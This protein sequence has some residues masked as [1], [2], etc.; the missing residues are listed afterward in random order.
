MQS[1]D[2]LCLS[3]RPPNTFRPKTAYSKSDL[4]DH[5]SLTA[6]NPCCAASPQRIACSLIRPLF[7]SQ[8]YSTPKY[9]AS[10]IAAA[11]TPQMC[12][13]SLS[14]VNTC[15]LSHLRFPRPRN[16]GHAEREVD[17]VRLLFGRQTA[18]GHQHAHDAG[19][20][21]V[22]ISLMN[23]AKWLLGSR[24]WKSSAEVFSV[25]PQKI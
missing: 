8:R 23:H 9:I 10:P 6:H 24:Q 3:S 5:S 25:H 21:L 7:R 2:A 14:H 16:D 13:A 18:R 20:D 15:S 1:D 12:R 11:T 19:V 22:R 17:V 4:H